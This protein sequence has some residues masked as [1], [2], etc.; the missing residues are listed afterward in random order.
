MVVIVRLDV[1]HRFGQ[2]EPGI[3]RSDVR[4]ERGD[5]GEA[6]RTRGHA[7]PPRHETAHAHDLYQHAVNP[8]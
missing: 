6:A 7:S 3:W 4:T 2:V 5:A 8:M 1:F